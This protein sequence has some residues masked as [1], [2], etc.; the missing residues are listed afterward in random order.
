VD[1]L[2]LAGG[3]KSYVK[4]L[5]RVGRGMRKKAGDNRIVIVDF[6]DDTNDYLLSHSEER[7]ETYTQEGFAIRVA[8][9]ITC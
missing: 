8:D 1:V 2:V 7:I 4:L 6:I 3:G 5:Q 9:T